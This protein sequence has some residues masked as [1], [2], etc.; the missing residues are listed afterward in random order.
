ME[1]PSALSRKFSIKSTI[2]CMFL[3]TA[4]ITA[5]FAISLQ[6]YFGKQTSRDYVL[7]KL[8]VAS[9]QVSDYLQR[10]ESNAISSAQLLRSVALSTDHTF[11]EQEI[12]DIFIRVLTDNPL[13]NSLYFGLDNDDFYQVINL[14][15]SSIVRKKLGA[16]AL[17]RWVIVKISGD[18]GSRVK[19]SY[20]FTSE[21][22]LTRQI[23]EISDY[24][25]SR[26]PWF[27]KASQ[28]SVFKTAPY[29]FQ[30]LR[31]TGKTYS[32]RSGRGVIGI[33]IVLSS[34]ENKIVPLEL[35]LLPN[36]G[37]ETFIFNQRGGV[38]ASNTKL[39]DNILIPESVPLKLTEEQKAIIQSSPSL[40]VSNQNSWGPYDYSQSGEPM[41]YAIDVLALIAQ[42][43]GI[44]LKY[45]NGFDSKT[46]SG[47]YQKGHLD[48]IHSV[49][50][51]PKTFGERSLPIFKSY[52]AVAERDTKSS[53]RVLQDI[54]TENIG[55]VA[56]FGMKQ[57]LSEYYPT[58]STIEF[59]GL[60]E[61]RKALDSGKIQY[62][63][64]TELTLSDTD[65][66]GNNTPLKIST[67]N[68]REPVSFHLFMRE[69]NADLLAII[70]Q[71]IGEITPK[72]R[73]ALSRKWLDAKWQ[74]EG[75]LPYKEV[76]QF[77]ARRDK[78]NTMVKI[79][80]NGESKYLYIS[81]LKSHFSSSDYF[82]VLI[83]EDI[84]SSAVVDHM[85]K[86]I[87]ATMFLMATLCPFVWNFGAPVVRRIKDL[88]RETAKIKARNFSDVRIVPSRIAEVSELSQSICEMG[89]AIGL[90]EKR[91]EEF[92]DAIVQLIAQAVDD[93]SPYTA[94]HCNR[95]PEIA[96]MLA[97]AAEKSQKLA[98]RNFAFKN[99]DEKREF[100]I[101]AWLHDC[102]KITTP[103]HIV[104]KGTKLGANY[105]R[106]NEI[107]TRFE[108]LWRDAEIH[109]YQS[110]IDGKK[111]PEEL[112]GQLNARK[113]SLTQ[114]FEFI[115]NVN[116]GGE[117]MSKEQLERIK[118]IAQQK[119]L[120]YFDDSL[121]LSPFEETKRSKEKVSLPAVEHLLADKPEHIT[122]RFRP[123]EFDPNLGIKMTVPEYEYNHGEIY[124][125]SISRGTLTEEE[126][127]KIN[128]HVISSIKMLEALPF[129][130]ELS[131]VPSYA[132]TH[133]ETLRGTGYPR[134][135]KA[136]DLSILDRILA[137]ADIFEALTAAD[138]PYKR[139]K[140]VSVALDIM[141]KMALDQ[142]ID[143]DLFLLFLESGVY[144]EYANIFL[145]DNQNDKVDIR[146]YFKGY[147][148]V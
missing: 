131:K 64:D 140:P 77:A 102:G 101:A 12:R 121:G 48:I 24:Y 141:Y 114:D 45:I 94:G 61:A 4:T 33:D 89:K 118:Q 20:Y 83:P 65:F 139:A 26:R 31:T 95:V 138:R 73:E 92:L 44:E 90:H 148:L 133:H 122:R 97:D 124:N 3:I 115:A 130:P 136:E 28:E 35:G 58:L 67:F 120:R 112:L 43:T 7:S 116:I 93:K 32:V 66:L 98:F 127:Y 119:W 126:R 78:H 10:V 104:D 62:I 125:L 71:A 103:E 105:N 129:P 82:A 79:E 135:L 107:R 37:A 147:E 13:F 81:Q 85:F 22:K 72:Q 80:I 144:L 34:V 123:I 5:A 108:V 142:N 46:L 59:P 41:G 60:D 36:S 53:Q 49:V 110:I 75:V 27:V 25:P 47:K 88:E 111:N 137:I 106:I 14:A 86:S 15:S 132:S 1:L 52:L 18:P 8:S 128:E 87:T 113:L 96:M 99:E 91:Q 56:G 23:N 40:I 143:I 69:N 38:I 100:K 2:G 50:G 30:N 145:P 134:G 16:A 11:S 74:Q 9:D 84:V 6:Y 76:H 42:Q 68:E 51:D 54:D 63:L 57:W 17:E 146:K 29:L 39:Q 55:I 70:N 109:Y 117:S 21:F 19:Q